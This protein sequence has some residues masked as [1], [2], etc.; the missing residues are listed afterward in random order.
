M[1]SSLSIQTSAKISKKFLSAKM[2]IYGVIIG[3][4]AFSALFFVSRYYIKIFGFPWPYILSIISFA[5]SFIIGFKKLQKIKDIILLAIGNVITILILGLL[6]VIVLSYIRFG[7]FS[8]FMPSEGGIPL[9]VFTLMWC[10]L[11]ILTVTPF[12]AIGSVIGIYIQRILK[13]LPP[14]PKR[15]YCMW[16]GSVMPP[17]IRICPSCGREPPSG[18]DTKICP[19]CRAVIPKLAKFCSECGTAQPY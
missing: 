14:P 18:V 9:I 4:I 15:R 16:C 13:P 7:Y 5:L 11:T 17:G 12:V 8:P 2:L 1:V 6:Y 3:I 10:C 19:N